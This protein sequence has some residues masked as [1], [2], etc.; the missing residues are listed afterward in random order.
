MLSLMAQEFRPGEPVGDPGV[1]SCNGPCRH[2]WI[3]HARAADIVT[4]Q[5]T[6]IAPAAYPGLAAGCQG[7]GW[8][9]GAESA[10][11]WAEIPNR[12]RQRD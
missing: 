6:R 7:T 8:V 11:G 2:T 3:A 10:S 12:I 4:R 5:G 1:Y 9:R